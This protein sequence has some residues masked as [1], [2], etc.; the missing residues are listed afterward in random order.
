MSY[1]ALNTLIGCIAIAAIL[2]STRGFWPTGP[3]Q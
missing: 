1:E 2:W 3:F